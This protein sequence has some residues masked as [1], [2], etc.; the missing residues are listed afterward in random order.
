MWSRFKQFLKGDQRPVVS[1][2]DN[3]VLCTLNYSEDDECWITE[4][5]SARL[6]FRF[7]TA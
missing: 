4:E 1:R 6:P 7:F 2:V 5:D 3:A